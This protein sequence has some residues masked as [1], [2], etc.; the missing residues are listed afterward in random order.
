LLRQQRPCSMVRLSTVASPPPFQAPPSAA[1][2]AFA[3]ASSTS[4]PTAPAPAPAV[5][6][7]A[8]VLALRRS[9][10]SIGGRMSRARRVLKPA[11]AG[12]VAP[13]SSVC[14]SS[15]KIQAPDQLDGGLESLP[16][17]GCPCRPDQHLPANVVQAPMPQAPSAETPK[18]G[19]PLCGSSAASSSTAPAALAQAQ[20]YP[21]AAS[22]ADGCG[23]NAG[24]LS[25]AEVVALTQ[26]PRQGG[27]RKED[28][29]VWGM[30]GRCFEV[31]PAQFT[32]VYAFHICSSS[33]R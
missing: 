18:L 9:D 1:Q 28:R 5:V 27:G 20:T 25:Y 14:P 32:L 10:P 2:A 22:S 26:A 15:T 23:D 12:P 7:A 24:R 29:C 11:S 19:L 31:L 3:A 21:A 13:P 16:L 17:L 30:A 6:L 4:T 8:A 33:C